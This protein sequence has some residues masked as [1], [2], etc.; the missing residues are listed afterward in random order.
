MVRLR[1]LS[2]ATGCEVL[3]KIEMGNPGGSVKDRVARSVVLAALRDGRLKPGGAVVEGTSGSTGASLA[4]VANALG[5]GAVVA[6]PDDTSREKVETLRALGAVVALT[7]PCGIAHPGHYVNV[8][9]RIAAWI[10]ERAAWIEREKEKEQG[11]RKLAGSNDDAAADEIGAG[12]GARDR[13]IA[14]SP[15]S[16]SPA[17]SA[18]ASTSPTSPAPPLRSDFSRGVYVDAHLSAPLDVS[19]FSSAL[20]ADQFETPHNARAHV[21]TGLEIVEQ[22]GGRLDAFVAGAGTGGTLAGVSAALRARAPCARVVAADPPG[23]GVL[24]A[25]R[26]GVMFDVREAEGTRERHAV[27]TLV[28]GIGLNRWTRNFS[29]ARVDAAV[30]VEDPEAAEMAAYLVR[31]EG[32]WV[33]SSSAVAAAAAAKVAR[34]LGNEYRT[35]W[36]LPERRDGGGEETR[37]GREP[38]Q[39]HARNAAHLATAH[40]FSSSCDAVPPPVR[41]ASRPPPPPRVVVLFCDGGYRHLSKF[42]SPTVLEKAGIRLHGEGRD[43]GFLR[44]DDDMH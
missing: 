43:I 29:A 35:K 12:A 27:D 15:P 10:N 36:G 33:G 32:I 37:K 8:A 30:R 13:E 7:R 40:A 18:P 21:E 11:N 44:D 23:S 14:L 39:T 5:L 20:F 22:T 6:L 31:N 2:E 17:S 42:Y 19:R 1:S 3:A 9:R 26:R 38:S 25:V 34:R 24:N 28:E 16:A 4:V 41:D